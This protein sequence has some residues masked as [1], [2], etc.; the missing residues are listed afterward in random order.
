MGVVRVSGE[1][2]KQ[3]IRDQSEEA[4]RIKYALEYAPTSVI[5]IIH[6]G[7]E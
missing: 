1:D 6:S 2:R 3:L 7:T 5:H 4:I